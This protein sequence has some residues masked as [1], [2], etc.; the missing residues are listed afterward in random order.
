MKNCST[1][2]ELKSF[3]EFTKDKARKDGLDLSCR[4]CTSIRNRARYAKNKEAEAARKARAYAENRD[5]MLARNR[6]WREANREKERE[7]HKVYYAN[8]PHVFARRGTNRKESWSKIEKFEISKRDM[9]RLLIR[10]GGACSFCKRS[11]TDKLRPTWD[12]VV[13][14]SRGGTHGVGNLL[15]CCRTCNCSKNSRTLMEWR[16]SGT[17]RIV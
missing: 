13:P 8:N 15:P 9:Q 10:S 3:S 1:C 16:V 7:Q 11:F 4:T 14:V 5:V 6:R 12:H 17:C 2:G